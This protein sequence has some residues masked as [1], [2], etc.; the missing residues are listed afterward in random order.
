MQGVVFLGEQKL[1]IREFTDP[2]PGPRDVVVEIRAS[3]MCG[4]DLKPYRA[5]E[6]DSRP[7]VRGHEPCGVILSRGSSVTES[8]APIGARMMI[9]HYS[10]CEKCKHCLSGYSQ[11]CLES[12]KV[13]GLNANGGHATKMLVKPYMLVPLH[14]QLT[15]EEGAA[16]SCGTG[17]AYLALVR[18]GVSGRDTLAIF[19]QGPVGL[20]ATMLGKAMGARII[21]IDQVPERLT[22]A[23]DFGADVVLDA[24]NEDPIDAIKKLTNGEGAETTMDCTGNPNARVQAVKSAALWGRVC[25]VG[26]GNTTTFDISPDIIHKQLTIHGSWT[27]S[28]IGQAECAQFVID[29][30]LPLHKLLTHRFTLDEADKAYKLFNSHTTGKG[31]F[32]PT[33]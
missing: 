21:A 29:H 4:S 31:V 20:S 14:D 30:K 27:F 13:Y 7:I 33:V 2:I 1:E 24:R 10:G 19:G 6:A 15:F 12:H 26:E 16:I 22:L 23:A 17:T 32:L 11:M 5:S 8:E 9:H 25:L 3:G 18:L 28:T